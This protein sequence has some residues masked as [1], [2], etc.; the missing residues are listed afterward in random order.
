VGLVLLHP[1]GDYVNS[2]PV[3]LFEYMAAGLPVVASNFPL[4]R[5]IVEGKR[6][7]ITVDPLNSKAIAEAIE[8]LLSNPGEAM[9]MGENGR[10]AVEQH[11]NWKN[12]AKK[13]VNLYKELLLS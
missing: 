9:Q 6:C 3:K 10:Q 12:E 1:V 2:Y 5:R 11:Y 4:W 7:G 13:L 8:Y